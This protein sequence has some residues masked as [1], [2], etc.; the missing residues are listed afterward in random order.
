VSANITI[1]VKIRCCIEIIFDFLE[2]IFPYFNILW[3]ST[4]LIVCQQITF[5]RVLL[6][7]TLN[8]CLCDCVLIEKNYPHQISPLPQNSPDLFTIF[9][10]H[11]LNFTNLI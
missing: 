7:G 1:P 6:K 11:P 5:S 9:A 4:G 10:K 3:L 8:D 2:K